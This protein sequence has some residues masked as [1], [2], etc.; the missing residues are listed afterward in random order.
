MVTGV[1]TWALPILQV[2][3]ALAEHDVQ[4][5]ACRR[6]HGIQHTGRVQRRASPQRQQQQ[7]PHHRATYPD[8]V[9]R[10]S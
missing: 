9:D 7:Q 5:P 2:A 8:E 6:T 1:P 10:S 4:A 3:G